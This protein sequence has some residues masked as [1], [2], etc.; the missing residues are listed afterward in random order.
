MRHFFHRMHRCADD[1]EALWMMRGHRHGMGFGPF[2]FGFGDRAGG[3]HG[4]R[5]GRKLGSAD[6]QIVLLA[7]L[8]EQPSHG[9]ELIKAIEERSGGFYT[10]SPGVI[11]PAL[12]YLEEVGYADVA[13]DGAKKKYSITREGEAFLAENRESADAILSQLQH[14][15]SKM[16]RVR[17][18]FSGFD[19]DLAESKEILAARR[20]LKLAL[21]ESR[22]TTATER[23]RIV[24]IL[25]RA[26]AEIR[27]EKK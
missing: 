18:I 12:T 24:D 7:L 9:Y 13:V 15:G 10:P 22:P 6:L 19:D 27:G 21:R 25:K 23:R 5:L 14:F 8:A 26:A 2:A 17:D 3:G 11:Y 4:F 20:D 1:V 16:G